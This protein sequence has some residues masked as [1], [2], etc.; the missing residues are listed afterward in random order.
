GRVFQDSAAAKKYGGA[1]DAR[2]SPP[3][4]WPRMGRKKPKIQLQ[5]SRLLQHGQ[6]H[7]IAAA[8]GVLVA[9]ASDGAVAAQVVAGYL[10]QHA[11]AAAVQDFDFR[12][13]EHHRVVHE[14][15]ELGQRVFGALAAQVERGAEIGH[16]AGDVEA[17]AAAVGGGG[18][19]GGGFALAH[20]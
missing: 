17:L 14:A 19:A 16:A 1:P 9:Y 10:A 18:F 8:V 13:A 3:G 20:F 12:D 4:K 2:R 15:H 6:R 11:I 5:S 7:A